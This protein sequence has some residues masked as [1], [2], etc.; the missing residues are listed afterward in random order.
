MVLLG[1][2]GMIINSF[3]LY[4]LLCL[5]R[6]KHQTVHSILTIN[7]SIIE[8]LINTSTVIYMIPMIIFLNGEH[9]V[10]L[11]Y[12][13][14]FYPIAESISFGGFLPALAGTMV[15][16]TVNRLLGC[17]YPLTY[18][19]YATKGKVKILLL[20]GWILTIGLSVIS[21]IFDLRN[22][23]YYALGPMQL[24]LLSLFVFAYAVIFKGLVKSKRQF[25]RTS[26]HPQNIS[27][28]N[29]FRN[30]RMYTSVLLVS[31][32]CVCWI[33][34][35]FSFSIAF[36]LEILSEEVVYAVTLM[37]SLNT[38]I[39]PF[40]YIYV[41]NDIRK[42]MWRKLHVLKLMCNV[43]CMS[44]KTQPV[45]RRPTVPLG[46]PHVVDSNV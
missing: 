10:F 26:S 18:R 46:P 31:S 12:I 6:S 13:G 37:L 2:I 8:I 45:Q 20:C 28:F 44:W 3:G 38:L 14:K 27:L 16:I 4:L 33:I 36:M 22:I 5:H 35:T 32:F 24:V 29:I 42:L 23:L 21:F 39:D 15:F 17:V 25:A 11:Q 1:I 40:I 34:P 7:V 41:D 43:R 19:I 30:S 9:H